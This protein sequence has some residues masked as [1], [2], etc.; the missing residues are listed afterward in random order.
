MT[1]TTP[2]NADLFVATGCTHCPVVLNELSEQL[3][4][5]A[6]ASI[7]ITNIAVDNEKAAKLN[8][9]S[10]PWFS[11][12]NDNGLM[13][14]SGAHTPKEIQQWIKTAQQK[15]GMQLYIED[16]L[17]NGQL[18]TVVQAIEIAPAGFTSIIHMLEDE[19]TSMETRIGLDA[20]VEDF[21][22][23]ELLKNNI[24]AFKNIAR[25]NNLRL[26]IDALHYIALAGD[27]KQKDF[28]QKFTQH[29]DAQLKDAA[30]EALETLAETTS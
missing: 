28:I 12:S 27:T 11:L 9:R 3:K 10:V 30:T 25:G 23:T 5:G 14:F 16:A 26:Q 1:P 24:E 2:L 18:A 13:I 4:K 19:E 6:L 7:S 17:K 21:A 15:D 29:A 8:I 20:L 22:G